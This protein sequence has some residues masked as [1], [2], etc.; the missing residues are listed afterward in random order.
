MAADI[1]LYEKKIV[2]EFHKLDIYRT[3]GKSKTKI[4]FNDLTLHENLNYIKFT[5]KDT[6]EAFSLFDIT[7]TKFIGGEIPASIIQ[8]LAIR[9]TLTP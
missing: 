8:K 4:S 6:Q 7:K 5:L 1:E 2:D 3:K 9:S